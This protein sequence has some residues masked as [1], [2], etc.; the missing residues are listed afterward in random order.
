MNKEDSEYGHILRSKL[1]KKA[2]PNFA[3][4]I[5]QLHNYINDIAQFRQGYGISFSS[6]DANGITLEDFDIK[7]FTI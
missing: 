7:I 1:F 6:L 2:N 4:L 3:D 5:N